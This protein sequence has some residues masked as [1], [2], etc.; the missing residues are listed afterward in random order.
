MQTVC[1]ERAVSKRNDVSVKIDTFVVAEARIAAA[2]EGKSLA[3]YLTEA[4]QERNARVL[5]EFKSTGQP[6][7]ATK[8]KR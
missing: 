7:A 4:V 1:Q 2:V 5:S 8:P 6:E 3:E